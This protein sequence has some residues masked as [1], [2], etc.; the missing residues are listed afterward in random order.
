MNRVW[1][2]LIEPKRQIPENK[3]LF[4]DGALK[5]LII[6]LVIEQILVMA[7]GMADTLMISYAGEAA[8]SGVSLVDMIN[9]VFNYLFSALATGGTIVV[10]QYIGRK[11]AA[12]GRRAASQVF[13]ASVLL[14]L[15]LMAGSLAGNRQMLGLLFGSV[16]EAVMQAALTYLIISAFSY[17]FLAAYSACAALFRAMGN[18]RVTM[19]VSLGMNVVNIVGNAIAIFA[20]DAG[21]AGVAISSLISR[22]LAAA[23]M[24]VM[25]LNKDRQISLR[26][27]EIFAWDGAL[28]W[29]ILRIAV[30]NAVSSGLFQVC[31]VIQTSII[32][33]FGTAQIAAN[34]VANSLDMINSI[35]VSAMGLAMTTV[36]GQCAG[37]RDHDQVDYYTRKLM[38]ISIVGSTA[39]SSVVMLSL[40]LILKLYTLSAET[41]NYVY[42]LVCIHGVFS[43]VV[44]PL[45][46]TLSSAIRAT[47]DVNSMMIGQV[48]SILARLL[49]SFVFGVWMN[50]GIIGIWFAMVVQWSVQAAVDVWRFRSGAW[51]NY[52]AIKK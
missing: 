27:R 3:R 13:M 7:V 2:W 18:S 40:P 32:A 16:E 23:V 33:T 43:F 25:L 6:P 52:S 34:G 44:S 1:K 30:P 28:L 46:G 42:I 50:M 29:G 22:A 21:V 14:S 17:P 48:V 47:G 37:A 12:M 26:I 31:R 20:F 24:F 4:S 11:D 35:F 36:I 51:K 39:V 15:A 5:A 45:A 38:R 41:L 49:F 19:L 10:S 8:I 9:G